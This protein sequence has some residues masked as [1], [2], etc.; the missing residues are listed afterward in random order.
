MVYHIHTQQGVQST[1]QTFRLVGWLPRMLRHVTYMESPLLHPSLEGADTHV[2]NLLN[3][4]KP[5]V[6]IIRGKVL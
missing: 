3:F 4:I 2:C 6:I 5:G 1:K